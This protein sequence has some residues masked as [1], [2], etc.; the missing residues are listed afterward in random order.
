LREDC[1]IRDYRS[2]MGIEEYETEGVVENE[3]PPTPAQRRRQRAAEECHASVERMHFHLI[4]AGEG[5]GRHM[6]HAHSEDSAGHLHPKE[7]CAPGRADGGYWREL[8]PSR[9][10]PPPFPEET[11]QA[12]AVLMS[13]PKGPLMRWKLRL[14]CGHVVESTAHESYRSAS[15]A[16]GGESRCTSCGLDPATILAARPLGLLVSKD[17]RS[18]K[19]PAPRKLT[20]VNRLA[21]AEAEIERLRAELESLRAEQRDR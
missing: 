15:R 18:R 7:L 5:A 3:E 16:S 8:G 12:L 17:Q 1:D 19:P 11:L 14:Y 21:T 9:T 10:T 6:S 4:A 13:Q 20:D 2:F